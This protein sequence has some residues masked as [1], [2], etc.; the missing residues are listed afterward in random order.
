MED[1][2]IKI[3]GEDMFIS[4]G[5]RLK[6]I[7]EKTHRRLNYKRHIAQMRHAYLGEI[8]T[9]YIVMDSDFV[10]ALEDTLQEDGFGD[11]FHRQ[12]AGF[13]SD[14]SKVLYYI[15]REDKTIRYLCTVMGKKKSEIEKAIRLLFKQLNVAMTKEIV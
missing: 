3:G 1:I 7:I 2:E 8:D 11:V 13:D 10:F 5:D 12:I 14:T 6:T 15:L 9:P 4:V